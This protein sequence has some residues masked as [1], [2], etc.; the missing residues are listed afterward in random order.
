ME[1]KVTKSKAANMMLSI[2]PHAHDNPSSGPPAYTQSLLRLYFQYYLSGL[3][4][5]QHG[6]SDQLVI[7]TA[8]GVSIGAYRYIDERYQ[9]VSSESW[10]KDWPDGESK[11]RS[12]NLP[13][14][15]VRLMKEL[16]LW[17]PAAETLT[18]TGSQV[19]EFA[20]ACKA[21]GR[22]GI[23]R[24][25]WQGAQGFLVFAR[26]RLLTYETVFSADKGV[27]AGASHLP[28]IYRQTGSCTIEWFQAQ[29]GT[30][31]YHEQTLRLAGANWC[32]HILQRYLQMA[33]KS[34]LAAL[35]SDVNQVA[36][37]SSIYMQV[38]GDSLI[39]THEFA[40]FE[41]A[42]QAYRD[43]LYTMKTHISA[44]LGSGLT[45]QML[46]FTYELLDPEDRQILREIHLEP[47]I[48]ATKP[49]HV[50]S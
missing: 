3:I 44:V 22:S 42:A 27:E 1:G 41:D 45:G 15:A 13:R 25:S 38:V 47:G 5:I 48:L 7:L 16:L 39:D 21:H 26:G 34:L 29:A 11:V 33:G 35:S 32:K 36:H 46:A 24:F 6:S 49:L 30:P 43:L 37:L 14:E 19:V 10:L 23:A 50:D 4:E 40:S 17:Y 18:V 9:P 8:D 31:P 12:I 20:E 2:F 28:S